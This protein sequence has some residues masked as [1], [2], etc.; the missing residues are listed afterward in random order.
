MEEEA[1]PLDIL[2]LCAAPQLAAQVAAWLHGEWYAQRGEALHDVQARLLAGP[3][4]RFVA[5]VRAVPV[6]TFTLEETADPIAAR[7]LLCLS[8][9]FVAPAWR[10][11][12]IGRQL[13]EAALEQ[14]RRRRIS[15]L[16]LFTAS[17]A[18]WYAALGWG[19]VNIAPM[20]SAG[21]DVTAM[22]M[23]CKVRPPIRMN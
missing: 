20:Q 11:R 7:P 17:H 2:D 21:A 18:A 16:D 15:R 23:S 8:N 14:A 3:A 22:W 12:G 5:C 1:G 6:G 9:L 4:L 10:G 19:Y 13:C